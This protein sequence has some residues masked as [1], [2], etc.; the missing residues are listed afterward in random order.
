MPDL[1][2][3]L[4]HYEPQALLGQVPGHGETGLAAPTTTASSR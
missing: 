4:Q 2:T 1:R 3:S